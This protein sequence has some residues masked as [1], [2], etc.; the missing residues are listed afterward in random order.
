VTT[1]YTVSVDQVTTADLTVTF[2]YSGVA[3][4]G[5]DFNGVASVTIPSG[6]SSTTF[7]IATIDDNLA[8]GDELYTVS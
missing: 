1:D 6:A 5:T 7:N 8:E 4:D 2:N 3:Q